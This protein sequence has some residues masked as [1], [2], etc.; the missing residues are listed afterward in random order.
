VPT[1]LIL[2]EWDADTPPYMAQ[3]LYPLLVNAHPKKLVLLSQGTHGIMNELER[4]SLFDEVYRFLSDGL[5]S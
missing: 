1:L 5:Q 3:T 2:A 4:F